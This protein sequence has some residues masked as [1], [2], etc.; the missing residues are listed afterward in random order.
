MKKIFLSLLACVA[1][2]STSCDM[3]TVAPGV[4]PDDTAIDNITNAKYFR[5]FL[6]STLRGMNTG[7][8]VYGVE[9]Q[10][11]QFIGLNSNGNRGGE[12]SNG[13]MTSASS[14]PQAMYQGMY[15]RIAQTNFFI[16]E[17]EKLVNGGSLTE[18]ETADAHRYLAEAYFVRG[19]CYFFLLDHYCGIY[20]ESI[21]DEPGKG[22]QLVTKYDP[23]GD[24]SKYPGRST[25]NEAIA[26]INDDL[27]RAYD[28]LKAYEEAGNLENCTAGAPYLSSYTVDALRARMAL[29]IGDYPTAIEKAKNVIANANYKL[30]SGRAYVNMWSDTNTDELIFAPFV[31][32]NESRSISSICQ[33]W[34][35]WWAGD[36]C[37]T[38]YIPREETLFAYG[39]NDI[40]ISA[41]FKINNCNIEGGTAQAYIFNKWPGVAALSTGTNMYLNAPKPFR[42]SEQYLILAEAAAETH[43]DDIANN[44][45]KTIRA[46]R[47]G[48]YVH[49]DLAAADLIQAVRDE[50]SLELIGEGFRMSDLKR[51]KV[52]WNRQSTYDDL[53]PAITPSLSVVGLKVSYSSDDYRYVWPIPAPEM[54]INPQLK[55]QQNPNY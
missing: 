36:P 21:G 51:W 2:L 27:T 24:T 6:Y 54:E 14:G 53:N 47:I 13:N 55:G 12:W 45:L 41:F 43:Q 11:D 16:E 49:T 7:S 1:L 3:D 40:R 34:N 52:A 19:Y 17:T 18:A 48:N 35:Y 37:Q 15:T 25:M 20:D 30:A 44:A 9:L 46:A 31:D 10:M 5:N 50:R 8:A 26:Q 4:L 38:D 29:V 33:G 28:G 23:T 42:I 22:L 32:V 39:D